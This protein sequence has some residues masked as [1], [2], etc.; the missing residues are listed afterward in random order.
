[1]LSSWIYEFSDIFLKNEKSGALISHDGD[2]LFGK[3]DLPF[4]ISGF[5]HLAENSLKYI[6]LR[7]GEVLLTNDSYS[8]GSF[9]HRYTFLMSL[10][11]AEGNHPGLFLC[12]RR[13][14]APGLKIS[15]KLDDEGLR[16]PPTPIYQG[17]QVVT[18]IL[19]AMSLHPV[20][21]EGFKGWVL[22]TIQE[23]SEMRKRWRVLERNCKLPFS[24]AE[25]KKF[26]Q[27]SQKH[28][29]E[30]IFEKAQGEARSE[31][32]LDSGEVLKLHLEI[33]NGFVKADFS[34]SSPGFKTH[35]PDLATFGACHE[36]LAQFY[37]LKCLQNSG[38]FSV[39]QVTKP[40]G[41]FLSARYPSSTHQ[42]LR[43][44]VA[45]VQL[46]MSIA[47][48]QIVKSSQPLLAG[49]DIKL[50]MAFG[51]GQ[52]WLSKWSAK[53]FCE[54]VS[55]EKIESQ[56]PVHFTRLEKNQEKMHLS[57]EL[58]TLAACQIRWL[59]DFTL[60]P[61]RAPR[62]FQPP[63]PNQIESQN[64]KGEWIPLPSQGATDL[65]PG[66]RLRF[67]LH[68]LFVRSV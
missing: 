35:V 57:L 46:A 9:L 22:N 50:E 12:V 8:G 44:G 59:T 40:L 67:N 65:M 37:D 34:G 30:K 28:M 52:H 64:E 27:F 62:G 18:P 54:S 60:N 43:S 19:E 11:A 58:Q 49:S 20:C 3:S 29:T 51:D 32:R 47:L 25:I 1:M 48:H 23:L 13:T 41:C 15:N 42:G 55:L 2:L 14:F 4:E 45:A 56:Y 10:S 68:G 24:S 31:V 33:H 63:P 6:P 38:S 5:Q 16:I 39:L 21:P 17:G 26:L 36:A 66:T 53:E 7:P 61:V